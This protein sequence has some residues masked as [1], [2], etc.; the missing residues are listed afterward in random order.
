MTVLISIEPF[1]PFVTFEMP[2]SPARAALPASYH[3]TPKTAVA[4]SLR[5]N[6]F[7]PFPG[8]DSRNSP[9]A[10]RDAIKAGITADLMKYL[11]PIFF[12]I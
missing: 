7:A 11:P 1:H 2:F 6:V 10:V 9:A 4:L 3:E 8:G 12:S 5:E